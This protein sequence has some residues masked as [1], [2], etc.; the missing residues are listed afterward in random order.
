MDVAG[1]VEP[2]GNIVKGS[3]GEVARDLKHI[4]AIQ[5]TINCQQK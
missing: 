4:L 3:T 5:L 2:M 1:G